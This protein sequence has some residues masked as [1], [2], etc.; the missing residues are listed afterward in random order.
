M[1]KLNGTIVIPT[2]FPDKTSQVWRLESFQYPDFT[3]IVTWEFENEAEFMHVAQL[4]ALIA[5]RTKTKTILELPFFPY[6]RQDKEI[7]ND[8][9]FAREVFANLLRA[10]PGIDKVK[11]I[12][13]HSSQN[14]GYFIVS[15]SPEKYIAKAVRAVGP[16]VIVF[17]DEGARTRYGKLFPTFDVITCTKTRDQATGKILA[18]EYAGQVKETDILLIVDDICDRGGT[19]MLCAAL[20]KNQVAEINLFTTHGIYSGGTEIIRDS[21]I[22]RIFNRKGEVF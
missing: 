14:D 15:E 10:L 3:N 20:F 5:S 8:T 21:G 9:T 7:S 19:F 13:I 17:P 12:D 2:I 11:T 16:T 22:S 6:A 4:F 18:M 1:I